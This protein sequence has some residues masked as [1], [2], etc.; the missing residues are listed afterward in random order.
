MS[1]KFL[2][3]IIIIAIS[4]VVCY[5]QVLDLDSLSVSCPSDSEYQNIIDDFNIVLV[6][7][8]EDYVKWSL[9]DPYL[10][11]PD[12]TAPSIFPLINKLRII[13]EQTFSKPL[14]FADNNTYEYMLSHFRNGGIEFN[15]RTGSPA[16]GGDWMFLN[17]NQAFWDGRSVNM[18]D[19]HGHFLLYYK[20]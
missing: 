13:R 12:S 19:L 20:V 10:F 16:G 9:Y 3:K 2:I 15:L 1:I 5:S 11:D 4:P 17:A 6:D 14:P 18:S 7:G 8:D